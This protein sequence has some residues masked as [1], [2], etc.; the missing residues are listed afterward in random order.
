MVDSKKERGLNTDDRLSENDDD[1]DY[2]YANHENDHFTMAPPPKTRNE[3]SP[4]EIPGFEKR[5]S[6]RISK[7][8]KVFVA[9]KR[10]GKK[11][12]ISTE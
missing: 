6:D 1:E 11:I 2:K 9:E 10:S 5:L 7:L 8:T 4:K 3:R 12:D